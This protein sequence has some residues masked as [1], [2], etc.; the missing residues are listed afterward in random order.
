M[1]NLFSEPTIA[2]EVLTVVAVILGEEICP[3]D[4]K[5]INEVD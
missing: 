3:D 1:T 4:S 2:V 5:V